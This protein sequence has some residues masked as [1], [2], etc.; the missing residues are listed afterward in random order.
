MNRYD[1]APPEIE[2]P[3][4]LPHEHAFIIQ[5]GTWA[6]ADKNSVTLRL[7]TACGMTHALFFT[8]NANFVWEEVR[9]RIAL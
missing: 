1:D 7:C 5:I 8:S 3:V 4:P 6:Y 2:P 9:E